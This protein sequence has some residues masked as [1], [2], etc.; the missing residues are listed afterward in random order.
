VTAQS[1]EDQVR[2]LL[3]HTVATVAYRAAKVLR[4]AP[5]GFDTLQL[6]PGTR[7]PIEILAHMA[8]LFEWAAQLIQG[9]QVWNDPPP[10][11]WDVECKRFF[12]ALGHF[13]ELVASSP[14]EVGELRRLFQGP[15]AD[16]LTHV[17]QLAMLRRRAGA[18]IRGENYYRAE[19]TVG[20]V[21]RQQ[22]EA[23][24]EFG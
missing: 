6:G 19:I 18:P 24:A 20:R 10:G 21:G 11:S 17:G 9:R 12:R 16:S 1:G 15:I 7:T 13:D 4:D 8:A 22:A 2:S 14:V 3:R 5:G 23:V